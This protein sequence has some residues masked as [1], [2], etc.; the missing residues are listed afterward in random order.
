MPSSKGD[1]FL[2]KKGPDESGPSD[3]DY[4]MMSQPM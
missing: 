1:G 4:L 3:R 2:D